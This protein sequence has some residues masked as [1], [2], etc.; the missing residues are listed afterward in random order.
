M[1]LQMPDDLEH[2]QRETLSNSS[3]MKSML[4]D[5]WYMAA[6]PDNA[7]I[8]EIRE[9]SYA[10]LTQQTEPSSRAETCS[11]PSILSGLDPSQL[12]SFISR[13][14]NSSFSSHEKILPNLSS[15]LDIQAPTS[16]SNDLLNSLSVN[17]GG[18]FGGFD[19][20]GNAGMLGSFG[21]TEGQS[22]VIGGL[23]VNIGTFSALGTLSSP[24]PSDNP[25][26]TGLSSSGCHSGILGGSLQS[27]SPSN[28]IGGLSTS[29]ISQHPGASSTFSNNQTQIAN[30]SNLSSRASSIMEP[31]C[32]SHSGL[33]SNLNGILGN[34]FGS[35]TFPTLINNGLATN[36]FG[37][38]F[39]NTFGNV[40]SGVRD[41]N[42]ATISRNFLGKEGFSRH[43]NFER[44]PFPSKLLSPLEMSPSSGSQLTLFQKR[45]A[46]R[47]VSV[48]RLP[49][50]ISPI[51]K[52][53]TSF[54]S[55]TQGEDSRVVPDE[56]SP[57]VRS[58]HKEEEQTTTQE[59][60][61]SQLS[62]SEETGELE[63]QTE[64]VKEDEDMGES[65]DGSGV[66]YE[67]DDPTAADGAFQILASNET[68][69]GRGQG[70][71]GMPAKNL[72]AE[73]R[74]RKKLNDRLLMLRSVVPKISKMDRA[75]ILGDAI[76]Y[77]KELLQRINDL[78]NEL[79]ATP[80]RAL[81]LN[82][83]PGFH[84]LA[85]GSANIP[86]RVKEECSSSLTGSEMQPPKVEVR[87][88]DGRALNIHMF[89]ARRPGLL[90]STMGAL[91]RLGLDVQQAVISCFNGFALDVFRAEQLP[92]GEVAPEV[93]KAVLLDTASSPKTI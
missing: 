41:V 83:P 63:T 5:D 1:S 90:L 69:V 76:E 20:S 91:D 86:C 48:P 33:N 58:R 74:R 47:N 43:A 85:P 3:F 11:T 73:R 51:L 59:M 8:D 75:S 81:V 7:L 70:K 23:A 15:L 29:P 79:E 27:L 62:V 55:S 4:D 36:V 26:W 92:E 13:T 6:T 57:C 88:R 71:K 67:T 34:S 61:Q 35:S 28:N 82:G 64:D 38:N 14:P 53:P 18:N 24:A 9:L 25:F 40:P 17:H 31:G 2:P 19:L 12:Q 66:L 39:G 45:A 37:T 10:H 22:S 89:C 77:L 44:V 32:E 16:N 54:P 30:F 84:P 50:P 46:Q 52:P 87:I 78:H 72:M 68:P 21:N 93:I 42:A 56:E 80:E 65:K 49:P 60:K